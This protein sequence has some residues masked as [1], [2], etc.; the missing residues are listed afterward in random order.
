L[1]LAPKGNP[2]PSC[3][4][5]WTPGGK[6]SLLNV[7]RESADL[8]IA[9]DLWVSPEKQ[10]ILRW[11]P[12]KPIQLTTGPMNYSQSTPSPDG[13]YIFAVGGERRGELLR[14]DLKTHRLEPYL[15]GISA[16]QL[17][18]SRD[19]KWV[20]YVTF[21]ESVLWRSKID[22]SKRLQLT[23]HPLLA[24]N[25]RWSPDGARIAFGGMLPGGAWKTYVVPAG[26]GRPERATQREDIEMDPTWALD[27]NSLIVGGL[28]HSWETRVSSIDLRT[29]RVSL[30]PGSEGLRSPRISP[31][32]R[33]I[34][35]LESQTDSKYFLFDQRTQKWSLLVK[36]AQGLAFPEWS[37]DSKYVYFSNW[38]ETKIHYLYR[39]NVVDKKLE[40]VAGIEVPEG[41]TGFWCPWMIAGPDGS[42]ILLRD[43]GIQEI[44]ALDVDLP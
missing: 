8:S 34:V 23:N 14:Y 42:P 21:P 22:G 15:S 33:F 13:K 17:G 2:S 44:Y 39:V 10:S 4:L 32:G 6:Y 29:G 40:R 9:A 3:W 11:K 38:S 26:G 7:A 31:D 30:I 28:V 36:G 19:G 41:V 37:G 12:A 16:D 24:S 5:D 43:L 18:F 25:P 20:A 35:A 1:L 27:G